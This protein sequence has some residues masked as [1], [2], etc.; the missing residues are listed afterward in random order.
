[1][2]E[3]MTPLNRIIVV[4]YGHRRNPNTHQVVQLEHQ[5]NETRGKTDDS[6]EIAQEKYQNNNM[7]A[8]N[9]HNKSVV[10]SLVYTGC[11]TKINQRQCITTT[12]HVF[13]KESENHYS[14]SFL[15]LDENLF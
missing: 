5:E 8:E 9:K 11:T 15:F 13:S 14:H 6:L 4:Q 1:M 2:V 10:F 12:E 7:F 3:S